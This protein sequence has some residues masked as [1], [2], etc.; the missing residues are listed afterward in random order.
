METTY[1]IGVEAPQP[2]SLASIRFAVV[3]SEGNVNKT[4]SL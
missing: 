4:V 1:P 3:V 2:D